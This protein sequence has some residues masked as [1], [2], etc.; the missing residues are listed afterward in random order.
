MKACL[1]DI[2]I[3]VAI[4]A[5][6]C[7]A[8]GTDSFALRRWRPDATAQPEEHR[9]SRAHVGRGKRNVETSVEYGDFYALVVLGKAAIADDAA[10]A[11]LE[12]SVTNFLSAAEAETKD[13]VQACAIDLAVRG[14]VAL[15]L[16][17]GCDF[18]TE[19]MNV[20]RLE[21]MRK[22]IK[23]A[24]E[25]VFGTGI[26]VFVSQNQLHRIP[27]PNITKNLTILGDPQLSSKRGAFDDTVRHVRRA[28]L[29][30]TPPTVEFS[31]P[32]DL[33][34]LDQHSLPLDGNYG[35]FGTGTGQTIYLIDTGVDT[36]HPEFATNRAIF[37]ADTIDNIGG[38]CNGHGT[39]TTGLAIGYFYGM[40]FTTR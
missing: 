23:R 7:A 25:N 21:F 11:R 30:E 32:W 27:T 37:M 22:Y 17:L 24:S 33:D 14:R 13:A 10:L 35:F 28:M 5:A 8:G 31:V 19:W 12:A 1:L 36:T 16:G 34:R 15:L 4:F 40:I 18:S 26:S 20:T 38:D 39:M 6:V 9:A 29:Q 2:F 3:L